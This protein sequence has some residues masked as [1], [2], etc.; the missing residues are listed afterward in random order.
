MTCLHGTTE[1]TWLQPCPDPQQSLIPVPTGHGCALPS[2]HLPLPTGILLTPAFHK[3]FLPPTD[4]HPVRV[5]PV[6]VPMCSSSC[7]ASEAKWRGPCFSP[8]QGMGR[9]GTLHRS[10]HWPFCFGG[11]ELPRATPGFCVPLQ[12][13]APPET[14]VETWEVTAQGR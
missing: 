4:T 13:E 10:R 11:E 2:R 1:G 8:T 12:R 5:F 7:W 9:A 3:L 6:S 14:E